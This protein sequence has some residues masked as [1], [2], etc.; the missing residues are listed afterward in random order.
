[1]GP[2]D[3]GRKSSDIRSKWLEH[4]KP[5][6][7]AGTGRPKSRAAG[8]R[9]TNARR[10]LNGRWGL[11]VNSET[12]PDRFPYRA[13]PSFALTELKGQTS[14]NQ[15]GS[16]QEQSCSQSLDPCWTGRISGQIFW[17]L[18]VGFAEDWR[19]RGGGM[20]PF[21]QNAETSTLLRFPFKKEKQQGSLLCCCFSAGGNDPSEPAQSGAFPG[22][23]F[24]G[25]DAYIPP[26]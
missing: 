23:D 9:R 3:L 2:K 6:L 14:Q 1:M 4:S 15:T 25:M 18:I 16:W 11:R 10:K 19:R 21:T 13:A 12:K 8:E 17:T 24:G 20:K 22:T 7:A 5:T 26:I